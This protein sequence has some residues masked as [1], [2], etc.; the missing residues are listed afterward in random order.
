VV[1]ISSCLFFLSFFSFLFFFRFLLLFV[2][3]YVG[4][5]MTYRPVLDWISDLL[6]AYTHPSDLRSSVANLHTLQF[7]VTHSLGFSVFT[8]RILATDLQ[9]SHCH[10]KSHVKN[11][12]TVWFLSCHF[13]PITGMCLRRPAPGCLPRTV[14]AGTCLPSR[15]LT[16]DVSADFT[17]LALGR[18]ITICSFI[19]FFLLLLHICIFRS[20]LIFPCS[21]W[22][23]SLKGW[24]HLEG[25]GVHAVIMV[26][27]KQAGGEL[28][29]S[30]ATISF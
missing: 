8:S 21:L 29:T 17:I 3:S 24:G 11:L 23:D 25:R 22:K 1:R 15:C 27:K 28:L 6:T 30:W 20:Y 9:Q 12:C 19:S 18:H 26:S 7:T 14:F 10:F 2:L 16:M 4:L 5:S 13:F